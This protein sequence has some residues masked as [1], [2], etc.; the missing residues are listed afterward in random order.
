[1]LI[2]GVARLFRI[3]NG[4]WA[5]HEIDRTLIYIYCGKNKVLLLDTGF[6]LL[7]L[8]QLLKELCP[9]KKIL[10]VNTHAHGDHTGGNGQFDEIWTGMGDRRKAA[11]GLS[12]EETELFREHFF[13]DCPYLDRETAER[14]SPEP[15]KNTF[16]LK[17]SDVLDLGGITLEVLETPGHTKG[18]ICLLDRENGRLFTGDMVLTWCA[19]G[20]LKES[21]SLREYGESIHRLAFL[22]GIKEVFPSHGKAGGLPGWPLWRLDPQVIREYD[23]GIQMVLNGKTRGTL[24]S[25]FLGDGKQALF[26][27]GG[28]TYREDRLE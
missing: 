27:I 15:A 24:Y 26:D 4:L 5:V 7:D 2:Q 12:P 23:E 25:C 8:K 22:P 16:G 11:S 13:R 18:S 17:D 3:G 1:M 21:A 10:A 14:W 9:N 28:I 19:W 6:G 20:H